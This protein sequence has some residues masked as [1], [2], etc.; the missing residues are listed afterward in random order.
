VASFFVSRVDAEV[1]K[2]LDAIGSDEAKALRGQAAIA[3]ARL[4]YALYEDVFNTE[5]FATLETQGANRQRP[6]WASTGVKDPAYSDT[7][8]VTELVVANTVNTMPEKTMQAFADH[9][10]VR[11]DLVSGT[12]AEAQKLMDDLEA[13]GISYDDVV[14]VLEREGVEKFEASWSELVET[15]QTALEEAKD[16]AKSPGQGASPTVDDDAV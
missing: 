1:D 2:R 12:E 10:E 5:R 7:M 9:G 16:G 8:Y 4:A 13:I 6:L 15:V 3:N 14:D 11:G